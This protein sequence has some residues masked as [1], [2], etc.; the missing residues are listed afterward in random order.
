[1]LMGESVILCS[2]CVKLAGAFAAGQPFGAEIGILTVQALLLVGWS[3]TCGYIV[4]SISR[5]TAWF[6]IVA[7]CSPCLFCLSRFRIES[8]SRLS[9]LLFVLP[10][11]GGLWQGLKGPRVKPRSGVAAAAIITALAVIAQ[12]GVAGAAGNA[13]G[14]ICSLVQTWPSWC[15]ALASLNAAKRGV[16]TKRPAFEI[17]QHELN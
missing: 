8:L 6:S 13:L 14:W 3:W 15:L 11:A 7:Y 4:G 17:E 5:R 16:G 12:F 9:L 1:M 2:G 10:L